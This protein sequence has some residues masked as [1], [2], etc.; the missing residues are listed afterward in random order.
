M[1]AK[2]P[3]DNIKAT[4]RGSCQATATPLTTYVPYRDP[5]PA[6]SLSISSGTPAPAKPIKLRL[7]IK[8]G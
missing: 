6:A 8:R 5:Q 7:R 4:P 1:K 3:A 2:A